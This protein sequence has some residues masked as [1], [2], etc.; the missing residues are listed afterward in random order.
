MFVIESS[1]K[2]WQSAWRAC[3]KTSQSSLVNALL[4]TCAF[5]QVPQAL[6]ITL[7]FF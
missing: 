6:S 5:R 3:A 2:L 7:W 4:T 1:R